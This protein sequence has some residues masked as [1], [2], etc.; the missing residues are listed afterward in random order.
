MIWHYD[1]HWSAKDRNNRVEEVLHLLHIEKCADTAWIHRDC[2][3]QRSPGRTP[4]CWGHWR[5]E[6]RDAWHLRLRFHEISS[7]LHVLYRRFQ[8]WNCITERSVIMLLPCFC[9]SLNPCYFSFFLSSASAFGR[10]WAKTLERWHGN[11]WWSA[12]GALDRGQ[13]MLDPTGGSR[14]VPSQHTMSQDRNSSC[15]YM[16]MA[17][18]I[19]I[20]YTYTYM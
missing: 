2:C 15:G 7:G 14:L 17:S 5:W 8:C 16:I 10:R 20:I 12:T 18:A 3:L 19:H 9:W 4:W 1:M 6:N 11:Y 13:M